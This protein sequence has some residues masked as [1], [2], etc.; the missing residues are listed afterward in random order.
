MFQFKRDF[1]EVFCGSRSL[2]FSR[3]LNPAMQTFENWLAVNRDRIP[4]E[5]E[6]RRAS[7]R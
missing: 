5:T 7:E 1:E 3:E 2:A 4:L 6:S